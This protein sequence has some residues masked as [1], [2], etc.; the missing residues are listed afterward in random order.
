[1]DKKE[2]AWTLINIR[3]ELDRIV[4][5]T[6]DDEKVPAIYWH[7]EM[8]KNKKRG[9]TLDF[10]KAYIPQLSKKH[11]LR[12]GAISNLIKKY[13]HTDVT[14]LIAKPAAQLDFAKDVLKTVTQ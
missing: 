9:L 2:L 11:K 10:L 14:Y 1:M 12:S 4:D 5:A 13:Q 7:R 6:A 8:D 3:N